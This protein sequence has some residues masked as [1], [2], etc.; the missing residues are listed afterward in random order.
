[1]SLR[2]KL[3]ATTIVGAMLSAGVP[4]AASA[5][6]A[7]P[8]PSEST[9]VLMELAPVQSLI[10]AAAPA[11]ISL[12]DA[13]P[14]LPRGPQVPSA[15]ATPNPTGKVV[16]PGVTLYSNLQRGIDGAVVTTAT[17][18]S[19]IVVLRDATAA[20]TVAFPLNLR[21][22]S[23]AV[24]DSLG[25]VLVLSASGRMTGRVSAPFAVDAR[26]RSLETSYRLS[27]GVLTQSV[28][29]AGASFPVVADPHYTRGWVTGTVYFNKNETLKIALGTGFLTAIAAFAPPP[30]DIVLVTVAG[31]ATAYAG[32]AV[33]T[34]Q[35]IKIKSTGT[36]GYYSGSQGDG[37]CR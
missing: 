12:R 30:F 28:N 33:G 4:A 26:G 16:R 31:L 13:D 23:T 18:Q 35:C 29:T 8:G 25:G 24:I 22:G 6:T 34:G 15:K 17:S 36:I 27:G 9:R 19:N 3:L 21:P 32:Y 1:M 5:Q 2:M 7:A 11:S 14:S 37:Y 10:D 20:T